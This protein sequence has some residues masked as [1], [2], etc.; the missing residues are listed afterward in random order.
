MPVCSSVRTGSTATPLPCKSL[1]ASLTSATSKAKCLSPRAIERLETYTPPWPLPKLFRIKKDGKLDLA[2]FQGDTINTPSM[3]CVEDYL[4][5]LT[6]AESIGGLKGLFARADAN[7][8]VIYDW[9]D[10]T[11]G[12]S[13]L[14]VDPVTRSNTSICLT[15]SSPAVTGLSATAQAAFARSIVDVL[16]REGVARDISSYKDAPPGLRIWTGATV[17]AANL[18]ALTPWIDWAYAR[19]LTTV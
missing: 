2:I 4:D 5:A 18:A 9:I 8:K 7:A 14:A 1:I 6:W 13:G 11:P 3:M 10:R 16:D 12:I 19:A 17:E 15:F